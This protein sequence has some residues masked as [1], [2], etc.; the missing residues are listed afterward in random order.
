M[1]QF[2]N[3]VL[4]SRLRCHQRSTYKL[5]ALLNEG[6]QLPPFPH[7]APSRLRQIASHAKLRITTPPPS[8]P[9]RPRRW[10]SGLLHPAFGVQLWHTRMFGSQSDNAAIFNQRLPTHGR[11]YSRG[12]LCVSEELTNISS[13]QV[14]RLRAWKAKGKRKAVENSTGP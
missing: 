4:K 5:S 10:P 2:Y 8:D 13:L 6:C 12:I 1:S 14:V 11:V 3:L 7:I 9:K